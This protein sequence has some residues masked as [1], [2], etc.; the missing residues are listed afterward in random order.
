MRITIVFGPFLPVPPVLGG[1]VEK[2]HLGL[3]QA[4]R[5]AGH[6]V[7]LISRQY[8]GFAESE[9]ANGIAH[10][11]VPAFDRA[12]SLAMNLVLDF[13]YALRVARMLPPSDVTVTNSFFLP[14]VLRRRSAGKIY[15]HVARMPKHQMWLY[16]RADRLQAISRNVADE[17][18]RQAPALAPKVRTIGYP[19]PD[20]YF[21][22]GATQPRRKVILFV[23]R[24]AREKG[25]HLLLRA[26][27]SMRARGPAAA[28][29]DWRLRIVGPHDVTQGGDGTAYFNELT[30]LGAPLGTACEFVGAV[31]DERALINEYQSASIFVYP[32]VAETGE[33]FGLAP[34]EAMAAGC[35]VVVSDL[36]CF[37]D[38]VEDGANA[39]RFNHRDAHPAD[40]LA[41]TLRQLVSQSELAASIAS[42]GMASAQEF[43]TSA[44]AAKMLDDFAQLAGARSGT[45]ATQACVRMGS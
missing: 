42:K 4:Y 18:I 8:P 36:R 43:R 44:I 38:F 12:S 15:V 28:V 10:V 3:A 27:A 24:I 25:V 31:F 32:S 35:A 26:F 11:R 23:G 9:N 6:E 19:V 16:S 37:D 22:V 17:I 34:L 1:A 5:A 41:A 20:A 40:E 13:R 7:T 2:V 14:V 33:A 21:P 30:R 45:S 29:D 39:L